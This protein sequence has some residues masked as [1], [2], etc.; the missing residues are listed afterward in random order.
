MRTKAHALTACALIGAAYAVLTL[1]L[2][3]IS[4]GPIQMRLS[5]CL[6]IL[7]FFLPLSAWGLFLG[8]ALANLV[9]GNVF[10]VVF[11]SLATLLAGLLTAWAG[12]LRPCLGSRILAC[13]APVAVNALV[14]GAV[15]CQAYNGFHPLEDPEVFALYAGQIAL[16]EALVM[17]LVGLP[18]MYYLPGRRFFR[19]FIEKANT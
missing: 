9:T 5:E 7:P 6:C 19:E 1:A 3:P 10:D 16:G 4:Y 17:Y 13:S 11:G 14:I 8:C 12:R 18:L 2:S 15:I